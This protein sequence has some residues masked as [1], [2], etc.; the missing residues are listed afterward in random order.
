MLIGYR[1]G[2]GEPT[3]AILARVATQPESTRAR[4]DARGDGRL[5]GRAAVVHARRQTARAHDRPRQDRRRARRRA[6]DGRR[7]RDL[8][9]RRRRVGSRSPRRI[10]VPRGYRGR[11]ATAIA[12][13][14]PTRPRRTRWFD[15]RGL[16]LANGRGHRSS[17]AHH[18]RRLV[19]DR[20]LRRLRRSSVRPERAR[21]SI[22]TRRA[23]TSPRPRAARSPATSTTVTVTGTA[24]DDT[25]GRLGDGQRRP[26]GARGR[27]HV[28][29]DGPGRRRA[30]TSSTRSRSD[31]QG[32]AGK[33]SRAVVAGPMAPLAQAV[34]DAFTAT[35]SAQTFAA[36]GQRR[37]RLHHD[38]RSRG[39]GRA[40]Q[41]GRR[42]RRRPRLPLRRRARSRA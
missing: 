8:R 19:S 7:A 34:P 31:A 26:R 21:R 37:R 3:E 6:A 36:I 33:E 10:R 16:V 30:R 25:G 11:I 23:S 20:R 32:N 22:R 5:R 24:T 29:R 14:S 17:H 2:T 1:P 9:A 42:R 15:C 13:I 40:A 35:L 41:P 12:S 39:D 4:R 27:R 28:D 18:L 38:R